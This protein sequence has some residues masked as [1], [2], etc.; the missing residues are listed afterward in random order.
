VQLLEFLGATSSGF[1]HHCHIHLA[2]FWIA[3]TRG[4]PVK[5][6]HRWV[7]TLSF[8]RVYRN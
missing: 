2:H 4:G 7:V 6:R 5:R 3:A 8:D 1:S